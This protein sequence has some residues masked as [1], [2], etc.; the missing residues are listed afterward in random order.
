MKVNKFVNYHLKP[1]QHDETRR[2][3]WMGD[4]EETENVMAYLKQSLVKL[5]QV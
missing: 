1:K 4:L 5:P 3:K 2:I